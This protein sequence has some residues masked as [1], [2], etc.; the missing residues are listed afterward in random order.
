MPLLRDKALTTADQSEIGFIPKLCPDCTNPE[1][2]LGL[3]LSSLQVL[4]I[5]LFDLLQKQT[6]NLVDVAES[7]NWR[8]SRFHFRLSTVGDEPGIATAG[9]SGTHDKW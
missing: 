6:Q 8:N 3:V 4:H 5:V 1:H 9:V 2:C 7:R